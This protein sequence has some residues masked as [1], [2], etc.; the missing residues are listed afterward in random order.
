MCG[1]PIIYKEWEERHYLLRAGGEALFDDLPAPYQYYSRKYLYRFLDTRYSEKPHALW[2]NYIDRMYPV[3]TT[4]VKVADGV[5]TLEAENCFVSAV[6]LVPASA[7]DDFD[8][9]ADAARQAADGSV[10]EDAAAAGR[11]EAAAAA[12]RRP[13]FH[14][15]TRRRDGSAALDGSDGCGAGTAQAGVAAR[16]R[17]PGQTVTLRLAVVPFADLGR[18]EVSV[19]PGG[20]EAEPQRPG[21]P[22]AVYFQGYRYDGENLS[23]MALYPSASWEFERGVTQ[24][25]WLVLN[26][27]KDKKPGPY[28]C[29]V[30]FRPEKGEAVQLDLNLEVYPFTPEPVLPVS[31]GMYY[32]PREEPGLA[33]EVQRKLVKEQFQWMRKIG[34][35]AVQVGPA[36]VTGLGMGEK[37]QLQFDTTLYDLAPRP[38]WAG[39]RNNI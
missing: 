33:P 10:R 31:F 8:K 18:C 13:L 5:F 34:F 29:L 23:E 28:G 36:T 21:E 1:G 12:R 6:V 32:S 7:K 4:R 15:R 11:Q 17:A 26:I 20:M 38:A 30:T 3:Y 19:G 25:V 2:T 39:I 9:F 35:T 22:D 37:V 24:C 16:G 27:P 14:L